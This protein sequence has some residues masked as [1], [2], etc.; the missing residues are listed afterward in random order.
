M[1][2]VVC[3]L[4]GDEIFEGTVDDF[5]GRADKYF[6]EFFEYA[7]KWK[8]ILDIL[9]PN[10]CFVSDVQFDEAWK[11]DVERMYNDK[12]FHDKIIFEN[13]F[14]ELKEPVKS[15]FE[16]SL[17]LTLQRHQTRPTFN[18]KQFKS[19]SAETTLDKSQEVLYLT[20]ALD[21][22]LRNCYAMDKPLLEGASHEEIEKLLSH[23]KIDEKKP[24]M[25]ENLHFV[26]IGAGKGFLPV[27][28]SNELGIKTL[29]IEASLN[30]SRQF[31][32]RVA[33][34]A[35][36]NRVNVTSLNE[37]MRMCIGYVTENTNVEA[38]AANAVTYRKWAATVLSKPDE[39]LNKM[40]NFLLPDEAEDGTSKE[41]TIGFA[42]LKGIQTKKPRVIQGELAHEILSAPEDKVRLDPLETFCVS[43]HACGDLSVVSHEI[44]LKSKQCRG[45]ISVPCCF[46]HLSIEKCPLMDENKGL[47]DFMF[48]GD[49]EKR[50]DFLNH[51][52]SN[53]FVK[54]EKRHETIK[55]FIPREVI[56]AFV[57]PRV[58]VK[59]I[60]KLDSESEI[61]Y[62]CRV[63]ATFGNKDVTEKDVAD[64]FELVRS[65][66]W[67][68]FSQQLFREFFGHA[69]ES[70]IL[71]D[72]IT[73]YSKLCKE[74]EKADGSKYIIGMF[75]VMSPFSP[76]AFSQFSIKLN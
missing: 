62:F 76:R 7:K 75:D 6:A 11:D 61:E 54:F 33:L 19:L 46:Q 2:R 65:G 15:F 8:K 57:P 22:L 72:R 44:A 69:F 64:R 14:S 4:P 23:A 9:N 5:I 60:K 13:D 43:I 24:I 52:L 10:L 27:F 38:I 66:V 32:E 26:D 18:Q 37:L 73:Y 63:A 50:K 42:E 53:Y 70:L 16:E 49:V 39:P 40:R 25:R 58:S 59:K 41:E 3:V 56:S 36:K 45:A 68:L 30:H 20:N 12:E 21:V 17:H 71:I 35:K 67:K 48:E 55:G 31:I 1:S 28:M 74:L 34:L 51:A 29:S 47:F